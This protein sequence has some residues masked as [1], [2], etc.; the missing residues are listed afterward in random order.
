MHSPFLSMI[1]LAGT[2][3]I[4]HRW[5]VKVGPSSEGTV[6]TLIVLFLRTNRMGGLVGKQSP[7]LSFQ[8]EALIATHHLKY[9]CHFF[10][11]SHPSS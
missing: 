8:G 9:R 2:S 7:C 10:P 1:L 4:P 11:C 6:P 5:K 3:H